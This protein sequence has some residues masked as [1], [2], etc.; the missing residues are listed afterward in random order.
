MGSAFP[1]LRATADHGIRS[2]WSSITDSRDKHKQ[3]SEESHCGIADESSHTECA[4][5]SAIGMITARPRLRTLD[6][7]NPTPEGML[8]HVL[9]PTRRKGH[10]H[11]SPRKNR[12]QKARYLPDPPFLTDDDD[13]DQARPTKLNRSSA[14]ICWKPGEW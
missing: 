1:R 14:L 6:E 2:E 8:I 5:P 10:V 7:C 11:D 12:L 13:S 9:V 4:A 3:I